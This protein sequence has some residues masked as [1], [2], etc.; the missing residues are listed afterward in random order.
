MPLLLFIHDST[1]ANI[2]YHALPTTQIKRLQQIQTALARTVTHIR[3][4]LLQLNHFIGS[5]SIS[6]FS[7]KKSKLP[8]N[9][10]HKSQPSYLHKLIYIKLTGKTRSSDHLCASLPPLTSKLKFTDHSFRN[11]SPRRYN[12][13][14]T[15]VRFSVNKFIHLP[16]YHLFHSTHCLLH[17]ISSSA[18]SKHTSSLFHTPHSFTKFHTYLRLL[19]G[20]LRTARTRFSIREYTNTIA[21]R[22]YIKRLFIYYLLY[23]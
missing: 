14:P 16:F 12:Y 6:V 4:L 8:T 22:G 2:L 9:L 18:A 23:I 10:L 21:L 13:L 1:N 5:R 20:Q 3:V 7:P 11:D 17:A 15:N 19:T